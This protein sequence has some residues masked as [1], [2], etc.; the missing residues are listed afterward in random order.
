MSAIFSPFDYPT[1]LRCYSQISVPAN[2]GIKLVLLDL[3]IPSKNEMILSNNY[4]DE[5]SVV[6]A[7]EA[8]MSFSDKVIS[9]ITF[10]ADVWLGFLFGFNN[11]TTGFR[12]EVTRFSTGGK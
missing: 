12:M 5:V 2:F 11:V 8:T 9:V 4:I 10:R 3:K 7:N 1:Y 6:E